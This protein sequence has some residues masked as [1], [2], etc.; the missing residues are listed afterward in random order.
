[1]LQE[2]CHP[3]GRF[4]F[5]I[6]ESGAGLSRIIF[7][8][9]RV[10]DGV[11]FNGW[12]MKQILA[13]FSLCVLTVGA[14]EEKGEKIDS[15]LHDLDLRS[16]KVEGDVIWG[17]RRGA[18]EIVAYDYRKDVELGRLEAP[19]SL[20]LGATPLKAFVNYKGRLRSYGTD[21][22]EML[23]EIRVKLPVAETDKSVRDNLQWKMIDETLA[24]LGKRDE[25]GWVTIAIDISRAKEVWQKQDKLTFLGKV[26][27]DLLFSKPMALAC[28]ARDGEGRWTQK[29]EGAGE[30]RF[31]EGGKL[32][33]LGAQ[34]RLCDGKN[35]EEVWAFKL[36][37]GA[38][39]QSAVVLKDLI[40]FTFQGQ[41]AAVALKDGEVQWEKKGEY[42]G[43]VEKVRGIGDHLLVQTRFWLYGID[44]ASGKLLW[45]SDELR[46]EDT[47]QIGERHHLLAREKDAYV[48][49]DPATGKVLK[50][51]V[52][53]WKPGFRLA[54]FKERE[55]VSIDG[56]IRIREM[57]SLGE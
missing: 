24:V 10:Y 7:P 40:V 53:D 49:A 19:G 20:L 55:V 3:L 27:S 12:V 54:S 13:L 46:L 44:P 34:P 52:E 35:G 17:E 37:D 15:I 18:P 51:I 42:E 16:V 1:M 56:V 2:A 22:G 9:W 11:S 48:L 39:V 23:W 57:V 26:G 31:L 8:L 33:V 38:N 29:V 21:F 5:F 30:I 47:Y 36:P 28:L 14:Q 32:L 50:I 41:T 4:K 25:S 6:F 45:D 43:A